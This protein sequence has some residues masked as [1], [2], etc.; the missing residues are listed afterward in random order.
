[1]KVDGEDMRIVESGWYEGG[2]WA[3]DIKEDEEYRMF[4]R[5]DVFYDQFELQVRELES[6]D[7]GEL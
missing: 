4:T 6:L 2:H 7:R 1:M 5:N 3:G